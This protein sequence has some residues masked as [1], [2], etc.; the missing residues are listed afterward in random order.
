MLVALLENA[1]RNAE[2]RVL[3]ILKGRLTD[4]FNRTMDYSSTE[5][6]TLSYGDD[7]KRI[8]RS[9]AQKKKLVCAS[10]NHRGRHVD[11]ST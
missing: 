5:A 4:L 7:M 10:W 1:R 9:I 6:A 3:A 11:V 2:S 8:K